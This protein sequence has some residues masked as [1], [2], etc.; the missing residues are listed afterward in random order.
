[1][2]K[3]SKLFVLAGVILILLAIT[4]K[5]AG[6]HQLLGSKSIKLI[7]LLVMANT[8]FILA[9]LFKK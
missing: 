1:M 7:S 3:V 5:I 6:T 4:L 9:I 8:S 2:T